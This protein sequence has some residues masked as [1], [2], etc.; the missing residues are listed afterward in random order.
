MSVKLKVFRL[1]RLLSAAAPSGED[2]APFV[3]G[4][5]ADAGRL[6]LPAAAAAA[7]LQDSS[8]EEVQSSMFS[9]RLSFCLLMHICK[10]FLPR[11]RLANVFGGEGFQGEAIR[12]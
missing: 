11:L 10:N 7:R 9:F 1:A 3:F 6:D 12:N 8:R 4:T 5:L 2:S